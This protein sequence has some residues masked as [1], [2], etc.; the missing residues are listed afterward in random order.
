MPLKEGPVLV[1]SEIADI[2]ISHTKSPLTHCPL[3]AFDKV[4]R[5]VAECPG[6]CEM[7]FRLNDSKSSQN[8]SSL[9]FRIHEPNR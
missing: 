6:C 2:K 9:N 4:F 8:T 3:C 5:C 7:A 1:D